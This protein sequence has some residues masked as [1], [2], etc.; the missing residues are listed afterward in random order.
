M[1]AD[2]RDPTALPST[3]GA[4]AVLCR[5]G[6]TTDRT[7]ARGATSG[8]GRARTGSHVAPAGLPRAGANVILAWR[9]SPGPG[10]VSTGPG[11]LRPP[12]S[13]ALTYAMV[14]TTRDGA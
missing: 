12:S 10:A 11:V 3:L 7:G 14:D 1:P 9:V 5:T 13:T 4:V 2:R 8:A 6:G